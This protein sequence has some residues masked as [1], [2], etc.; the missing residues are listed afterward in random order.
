MSDDIDSDDEYDEDNDDDDDDD[1]DDDSKA[2]VSK[3]KGKTETVVID[4][5][6]GGF[7]FIKLGSAE[8][9]KVG[10][11]VIAIGNNLGFHGTV[12]DGIISAIGRATDDRIPI[13]YKQFP[14]IQTNASINPGSSGGGL[15]NMNGELIGINESIASA[16]GGNVGV[17]FAVPSN[18][19]IPLLRSV[20]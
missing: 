20:R 16:S 6:I 13:T 1:D 5:K 9:T 2:V 14:L 18:F 19:V 15:V 3:K 12:T 4:D 7:P 17:G 11:Y 10:D 8:I